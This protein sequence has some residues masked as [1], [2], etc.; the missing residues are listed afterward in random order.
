MASYGTPH[1]APD[2]TTENLDGPSHRPTEHR[3]PDEELLGGTLSVRVQER[4]FEVAIVLSPDRAN[5]YRYEREA[6]AETTGLERVWRRTLPQFFELLNVTEDGDTVGHVT[7]L[8]RTT[9]EV[10]TGDTTEAHTNV[11]V[12]I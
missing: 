3:P 4:A 11:S 9:R 2:P 10:M 12:Q 5:R 6:V 7:T 1:G 8:A